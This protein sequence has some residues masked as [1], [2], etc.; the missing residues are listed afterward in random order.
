P[1]NIVASIPPP[2]RKEALLQP[3][4][5]PP[6][7]R[8][9]VHSRRDPFRGPSAHRQDGQ[10][11]DVSTVPRMPLETTERKTRKRKV[12]AKEKGR[13]RLPPGGLANLRQPGRRP[14]ADSPAGRRSG[15]PA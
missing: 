12:V 13:T 2:S 10:A 6:R 8:D 5:R 14:L 3:A 11:P 15:F 7:P 4:G 9:A 1:L